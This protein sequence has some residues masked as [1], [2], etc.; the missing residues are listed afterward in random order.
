MFEKFTPIVAILVAIFILGCGGSSKTDPSMPT[1][2]VVPTVQPITVMKTVASGTAELIVAGD[3]SVSISPTVFTQGSNID[4]VLEPTK[5]KPAN[6]NVLLVGD[7]ALI[8]IVSTSPLQDKVTITVKN[9]GTR[10]DAKKTYYGILDSAS[11]AW[12]VTANF[13][14]ATG[15]Q[16]EF[17]VDKTAF[18]VSNGVSALK[19]TIAKLSFV[20]P[21]ESK[22]LVWMQGDQSAYYNNRVLVMVPGFNNSVSDLALAASELNKLHEWRGIYGFSYDWRQDAATSAKALGN[23]LD[24]LVSSGWEIDLLGHSRG[25]LICRA[26]MESNLRTRNVINFYSI[27]TPHEGVRLANAANLL[28]YL[29]GEYFNSVADT[30][31]P[32][33]VFAFDTEATDELFPGSNFIKTLNNPNRILLRGNVDY[34]ILGT[35][36]YN[37]IGGGDYLAGGDTGMGKNVPFEM[38]TAGAVNRHLAYVGDHGYFLKNLDGIDYLTHNVL[39]IPR[40][41]IVFTIEPQSSYIDIDSNQW[42][43]NIKIDNGHARKLKIIDMVIDVYSKSGE[44]VYTEWYNPNTLPDTEFPEDHY[45]WN[46]DMEIGETIDIPMACYPD[47]VRTPY[48][49]VDPLLKAMTMTV[50]IRYLQADTQYAL[51]QRISATFNGPNQYPTTPKLRSSMKRAIFSAAGRL[52]PV[53]SR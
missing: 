34:H 26:A 45:L 31:Q 8:T 43:I 21:I 17:V 28:D 23:A 30:D 51:S 38:L 24:S 7:R 48:A 10:F 37:N 50:T 25:G 18:V 49:Y 39:D 53:K 2:P 14:E 32:F 22:G 41:D 36:S 42:N 6:R 12:K 40:Q 16:V 20:S 11:G 33:G 27:C 3:V 5:L 47:R 4:V 46:R 15:D 1:T 13:V 52:F 44:W 9:L 29:R 19:G 35:R